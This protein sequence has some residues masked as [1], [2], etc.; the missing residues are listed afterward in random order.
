VHVLEHDKNWPASRERFQEAAGGPEDL[1]GGRP[2]PGAG[3]ES[4][5]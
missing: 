2:A 5:V 3:A 4:A 1:S